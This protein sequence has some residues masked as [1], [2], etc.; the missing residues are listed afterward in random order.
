VL[1][2]GASNENREWVRIQLPFSLVESRINNSNCYRGSLD[3]VTPCLKTTE[4][5]FKYS[6]PTFSVDSKEFK[7][8]F[9]QANNPDRIDFTR[10]MTK[11]RQELILAAGEVNAKKFNESILTAHA[12]N[13]WFST[14]DDPY[15]K[16]MPSEFLQANQ[17]VT[18]D[19]NLLSL[20]LSTLVR[21]GKVYVQLDLT[22]PC[23][24]Q[25]VCNGD[26]LVAVGDVKVSA[27]HLE[28][29]QEVLNGYDSPVSVKVKRND[30][31]ITVSVPRQ[32][33]SPIKAKAVTWDSDF[34]S[35]W[36]R[37]DYFDSNACTTFADSLR[38]LKKENGDLKSFILDL[39]G[40]AGG[41]LS[42][43]LCIASI[44]SNH[45]F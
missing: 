7:D 17:G 35:A 31:E 19:S 14:L 13:F 21:G 30:R 28:K 11:V 2:V 36:I 43:S 18:N 25:G 5:I 33:I 44:F 9:K 8:K 41:I 6:D 10:L 26:E 37:I 1:D 16:I 27:D 22:S 23:I 40:N 29:V 4:A 12:I 39:R 20:G 24:A 45:N 15:K 38:K 32:D 3:Q 34:S 42:T